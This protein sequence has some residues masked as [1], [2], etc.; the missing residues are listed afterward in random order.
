MAPQKLWA[1]GCPP[2]RVRLTRLVLAAVD[3]A[4]SWPALAGAPVTATTADTTVV[5]ATTDRSRH[6]IA[7]PTV[8]RPSLGTGVASPP[9][10][11]DGAGFAFA[12]IRGRRGRPGRC[13]CT[14]PAP[15][16]AGSC[17]G[18]APRW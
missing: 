16:P 12:T 5:A 9:S 11:T 1:L 15:Q 4:A 17:S 6:L 7:T 3:T 14:R 10:A 13:R 2:V 8:C 18:T